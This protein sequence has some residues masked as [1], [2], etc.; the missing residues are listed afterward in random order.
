MLLLSK[1]LLVFI[2]IS[3]TLLKYFLHYRELWCGLCCSCKCLHQSGLCCSR[4]CLHQRVL[5]CICTCLPYRGLCCT[6]PCLHYTN[7][8]NDKY[9]QTSGFWPRVRA[10]HFD[11]I[12]TINGALRAPRLSQLRCFYLFPKAFPQVRTRLPGAYIFPTELHCI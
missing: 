7:L 8:F 3:M 4:R 12:A 11:L 2:T 5:S 6:W 9:L 1:L 10:R